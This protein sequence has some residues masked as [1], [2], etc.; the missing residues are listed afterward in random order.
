MQIEKIPA[1]VVMAKHNQSAECVCKSCGQKAKEVLGMF[2]IKIGDVRF[3]IC[4]RCADKLFD[5]CLHIVCHINHMVKTP[6]EMNIINKR[7]RSK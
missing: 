2:D 5:K 4:D 1:T 7:K 6:L 3:T